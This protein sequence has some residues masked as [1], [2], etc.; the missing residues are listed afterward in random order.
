MPITDIKTFSARCE[1]RFVLNDTSLE[2]IQIKNPNYTFDRG[3]NL[4]TEKQIKLIARLRKKLIN[5]NGS[6]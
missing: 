4:K 1:N 3:H 5:K 2:E 6:C